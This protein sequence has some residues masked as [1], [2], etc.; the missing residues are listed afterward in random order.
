MR[1]KA[2]VIDGTQL[3]LD[4]ANLQIVQGFLAI[5]TNFCLGCILVFS[6]D[7][8][9]KVTT[10]CAAF[11]T[12]AVLGGLH[13]KT[14]SILNSEASSICSNSKM[15][16]LDEQNTV[17][18]KLA[19]VTYTGIA[20]WTLYAIFMT[21]ALISICGIGVLLTVASA[22]P[23][24]DYTIEVVANQADEKVADVEVIEHFESDHVEI[25]PTSKDSALAD[26]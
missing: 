21:F 2:G 14:I 24:R 1:K 16:T 6:R 23:Q 8:S 5:F 11:C 15:P 20:V 18:E 9:V 10:M 7:A 25:E 12:T 13:I 19:E 4:A 17:W 3:A 26:E 22:L